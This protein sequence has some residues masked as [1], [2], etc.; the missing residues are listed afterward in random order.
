VA[1]FLLLIFGSWILARRNLRL[2]RGDREGAFRVASFLFIVWMLAWLLAAHHVLEL[3]AEFGMFFVSCAEGLFVGAVIWVEYLALEPFA[4][5]RW[6]DLLISWT[7]L[8]SGRL[9]D[10]LVGRDILVGSLTGAAAMLIIVVQ[11]SVPAWK[12]V[13]GMTPLYPRSQAMGSPNV[14]AAEIV[15]CFGQA[16]F[17]TLGIMTVLVL[18]SVLLRKRWLAIGVTT[19][20][21]TAINLGGENAMVEL[22]ATLLYAA[23]LVFVAARF[24]LLAL[25]ANMLTVFLL[26]SCPL[27]LDFSQWYAGRTLFVLLIIVGLAFYG[28][29]TALGGKSPFGAA[30]LEEA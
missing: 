12:N 13:S 24:G 25:Y 8:L 19:L 22:P 23:L 21:V 26:L 20:L 29:R 11:Q 14:F 3:N 1:V 10:P 30:A 17:P 6:P 27:S 28:F 18:L 7:R 9:V 5:R 15:S 4:R 2:G 16:T